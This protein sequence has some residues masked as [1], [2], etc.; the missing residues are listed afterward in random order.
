LSSAR[1]KQ[2]TKVRHHEREKQL[3]RIALTKPAQAGSLEHSASS[4]ATS[5]PLWCGWPGSS[6]KSASHL[7]IL[8]KWVFAGAPAVL[9]YRSHALCFTVLPAVAVLS[10]PSV[11]KP[12]HFGSYK[13]SILSASVLHFFAWSYEQAGAPAWRRSLPGFVS[14]FVK[15]SKWCVSAG[16]GGPAGSADAIARKHEAA[17]DRASRMAMRAAAGERAGESKSCRSRVRAAAPG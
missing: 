3:L 7:S 10:H 17:A 16:T 12:A 9:T 4:F 8:R 14:V 13:H 11:L 15:A 1:G 5:S 2:R 6:S